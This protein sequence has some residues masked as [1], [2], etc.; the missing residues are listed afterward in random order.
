V[1]LQSWETAIWQRITLPF[2]AYGVFLRWVQRVSNLTTNRNLFGRDES[3]QVVLRKALK[4]E[5][6]SCLRLIL[7]SPSD[8]ASDEQVT[9]FLR[10]A[11]Y[12][13][14][15]LS[16]I[17]LAERRGVIVWAILPVYSPGRTMVLF[18]PPHV[19]PTLQDTIAPDLIARVLEDAAPHGTHLAQVL[20]DPDE[21]SVI[22]LYQRAGFSRLAELMYLSRDLRRENAPQLPA[23]FITKSYSTETHPLFI[24]AI[25]ASYNGSLDCPSLSGRRDI[26]DILAGHKAVG[27]FDPALWTVLLEHHHEPVGVSLLNRSPHSE[28]IELVYFGL[29]PSAR[30]RGLADVL[31]RHA[32]HTSVKHNVRTMTLAVDSRNTPALKLYYRHNFRNV[33]SRVALLRDLREQSVPASTLT[34]ALDQ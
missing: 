26:H 13:G 21:Q 2:P 28:S 19:A 12:R 10:F 32:L 18:S 33:C 16:G 22:Q 15:D 8:L 24:R 30:G 27:T 34:R 5:V 9:D 14:I 1:Y 29:I 20:L 4:E 25:T 31:L 6:H 17:H 3:P 7:G 11:I 23:G